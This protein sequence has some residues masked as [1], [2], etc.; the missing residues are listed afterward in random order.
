VEGFELVGKVDDFRDAIVRVVDVDG[1]DVAVVRYKDR[2]HA[3]SGHCTH[4]NYSFNYTRVKPG[5]VIICSSHI[6]V[7]QL[8]GG[9]YVGGQPADDL[10]QYEV[11]VNGNDV[12]VSR[13]AVSPPRQ[14]APGEVT[15][16]GC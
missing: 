10:P 9:K 13:S 11:R 1:T 8:E 5:D 12:Y 4:E 2:F 7:F 3:F 16:T 15:E 6:A 14:A